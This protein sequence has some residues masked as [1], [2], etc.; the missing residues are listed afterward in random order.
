MV[1]A[2]VASQYL[3]FNLEVWR[4]NDVNGLFRSLGTA[5]TYRVQHG[6][7][8][9]TFDKALTERLTFMQF[10]S[11]SQA[12]IRGVKEIVRARL[13]EILDSFYGQVRSTPQTRVFFADETLIGSAK[14]RQLS[15]WNTI[16]EGVFDAAYLGAEI[17]M[18]VAGAPGPV[19]AVQDQTARAA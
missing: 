4:W 1:I 14:S 15:H 5:S 17:N 12:D 13:P 6:K 9:M 18:P 16:S 11:S 3:S 19:L 7:V 2:T 8:S 10:G